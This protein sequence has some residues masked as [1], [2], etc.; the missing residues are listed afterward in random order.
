MTTHTTT[1]P[2]SQP[3]GLAIID[4]IRSASPAIWNTVL[5]MSA[6]A[7]LCV[8]LQYVDTRLINGVSVWMKPAKFFSSITIQFAT[9]GWAMSYLPQ[10]LQRQRS[11]TWP[12]LVMLASGWLEMAYIVFR[13]ARAEASHFNLET[14]FAQVAYSM[15]GLG[16]VSM[17]AVAGYIGFRLWRHRS[18]GLWTE[19]AALGLM[20]GALL[21]TLAGAYV[22]AQT[23]HSVGGD[24]TDATGTGFFGWST[25]G[26]DLRVAHFVGL[27]AAQI[28]PFAALSGRRSL[29][30]LAALLC[31]VL[32]AGT[33]LLAISGTPLFRA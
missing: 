5:A 28:I 10:Q 25:T 24:P 19:A 21:G 23:G 7:L 27:H 32:T 6:L 2:A 15:M 26:G 9:V 33:F 13:A 22:S 31:T 3:I 11:I 12:V 8:V 20:F 30:W 14:L 17:T 1:L 16:A 29:V 4:R 18:Q